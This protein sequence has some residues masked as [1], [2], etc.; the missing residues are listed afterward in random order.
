MKKKQTKE[1][2]KTREMKWVGGGSGM[3]WKVAGG[4]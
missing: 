4:K 3:R 2:E 1:E